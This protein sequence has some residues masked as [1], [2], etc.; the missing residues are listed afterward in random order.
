MEIEVLFSGE[1]TEFPDRQ[2]DNEARSNF[3]QNQINDVV[4]YYNKY[5]KLE[6]NNLDQI[7][8]GFQIKLKQL[9]WHKNKLISN[10]F[11]FNNEETFLL[12]ESLCNVFGEENIILH[13]H[14]IDEI[15]NKTLLDYGKIYAISEK[16]KS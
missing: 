9:R 13:I 7:E 4:N 2:C 10:S 15:D 16:I 1:S 12:Y 6:S 8:Y 5:K 14:T 3:T 11:Q